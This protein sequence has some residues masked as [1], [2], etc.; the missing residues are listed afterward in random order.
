MNRIPLFVFAS[1]SVLMV[2]CTSLESLSG[3]SY[4]RTSTRQAQSVELGTIISIDVVTIEGTSGTAGSIGGGLLGA[5]IG[6]NVGGGNGRLVGA[7][8]GGIAGAAGGSAIQHAATQKK[9]LEITVQ[10]DNGRTAAIVQEQ[11]KDTFAVGQRV[12]ILSG[13]GGTRV[14]P[15]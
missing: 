9:G 6:S 13:A 2:G 10:Y 7:A 1:L 8:V 12:R 11:G 5:A 15:L 4:S 3:D 14:R